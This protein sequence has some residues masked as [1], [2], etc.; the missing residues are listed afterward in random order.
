M[1]PKS[2]K[3]AADVENGLRNLARGIE[4]LGVRLEI[5]LRRDQPDQLL[6]DVDVGAL[7]RA[8]TDRAEQAV[9]ARA[10][11]RLAAFAGRVPVRVAA[12]AERFLVGEGEAGV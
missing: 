5:A 10:I 7:Q 1:P 4:R 6:G 12:L 9:I 11:D 3:S 8:G 2:L